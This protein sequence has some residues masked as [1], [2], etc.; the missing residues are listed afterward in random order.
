[1][2]QNSPI[3]PPENNFF[4]STCSPTAACKPCAVLS[5]KRFPGAHRVGLQRV[6]R[7]VFNPPQCKRHLCGPAALLCRL[8][9]GVTRQQMTEVRTRPGMAG[10]LLPWKSPGV[11]NSKNKSN[12]KSNDLSHRLRGSWR[13]FVWGKPHAPS[14]INPYATSPCL[15]FPEGLCQQEII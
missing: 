9:T 3:K 2:S 1:M 10:M 12:S 11:W 15:P 4:I 7:G 5:C 6:E 14:N 8:C 13:D